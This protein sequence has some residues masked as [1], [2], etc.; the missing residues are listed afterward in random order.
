LQ[1]HWVKIT[2]A[3]TARVAPLN[4]DLDWAVIFHFLCSFRG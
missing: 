4:R 3:N 2:A 1:P